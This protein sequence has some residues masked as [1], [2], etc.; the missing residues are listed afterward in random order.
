MEPR[1]NPEWMDALRE[2]IS[3]EALIDLRQLLVRGLRATLS[4][5]V[6][7]NLD[8]LVEDFVQEAIIKVLKSL[9]TFRG[10]SKFTT[11]AQ[12]IAVHVAF[13][14]LRR[15]R[16]KDISLRDLTET[17]DGDEYTPKI[18]TD[19]SISPEQETIQ[20][21]ILS[22]VYDLIETELTEKQKIAIKAGMIHGMPLEAIAEKLDT[23][24]NA[25]YKLI[26]DARKRLKKRLVEKTGLSVDEVMNM[27]TTQ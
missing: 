4:S 1:T 3:E 24:R 20:N 6:N 25:L 21:D 14:E 5:R 12:K 10:E 8:L 15:R 2:P 16:W 23:N 11:W 7:Q 19:P 22:I 18:L 17:A 9:E 26:H 13:T 27:F